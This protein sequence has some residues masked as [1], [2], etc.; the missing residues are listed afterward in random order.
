MNVGL[1]SSII[2]LLVNRKV[3]VARRSS[4]LRGCGLNS[5][6]WICMLRTPVMSFVVMLS[7][8]S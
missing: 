8:S 7:V 4:S 1:S 2:L 3:V 6:T 5:M